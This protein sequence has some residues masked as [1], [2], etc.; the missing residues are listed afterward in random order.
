MEIDFGAED[1]E[2]SMQRL[3]EIPAKAEFVTNPKLILLKQS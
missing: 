2:K 1:V 3:A